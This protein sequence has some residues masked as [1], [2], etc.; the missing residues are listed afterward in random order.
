MFLVLVL[1]HGSALAVANHLG[2]SRSFVSSHVKKHFPDLIPGKVDLANKFYNL[3]GKKRCGHCFKVS[4]LFTGLVC[5]K[6]IYMAEYRAKNRSI[7]NTGSAKLRA[8][9]IHRTPCWYS[10]E[11]DKVM[12]RLQSECRKLERKSGIKHHVD[13]IIPLQGKEVSGLHWRENW[14]ILTAEENVK[15]GNKWST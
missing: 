5:K 7:L 12:I 1:R 6:C 11:D 9:K 10:E 15:K 14:Q 2:I 8:D 3:I 4:E 13:H